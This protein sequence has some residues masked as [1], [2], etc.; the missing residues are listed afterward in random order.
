MSKLTHLDESGAANMVDVGDK[1][2]TMRIATASGCVTMQKQTLE[3]ILSGNAA[4][5]DVIGTARLAGIMAAKKTSD[6]IPLCHPLM[7]SKVSVDIE[8]DEALPGL[9]VSATVKLTG[10]TGVEMEALTAVSVACL[11]IYD[12]AKAADKGMVIG[13]IAVD[14]KTGGKSGDWQRS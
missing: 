5:G 10:K 13:N 2:E 1:A 11:T 3:L 6:L 12:M 8:P 7:L 4:K 14:S 9:R